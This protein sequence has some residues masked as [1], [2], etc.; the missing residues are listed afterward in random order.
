MFNSI[1][2]PLCVS[3]VAFAACLATLCAG[4]APRAKTEWECLPGQ[5]AKGG[6]GG[7]GG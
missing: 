7:V 4:R 5:G 1:S 2:T 3:I 6:G